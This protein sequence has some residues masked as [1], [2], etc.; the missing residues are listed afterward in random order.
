MSEHIAKEGK[1]EKAARW[2]RNANALGA[3]ACFAVGVLAPPV[4]VA[5]N[6]LGAVNLAQ[7]AGGE[8]VR[9]SARKRRKNNIPR[10]S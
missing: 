5:A 9:Q 8:I 7:A 2:Y 6:I 4:A 10:T 3:A 1:T